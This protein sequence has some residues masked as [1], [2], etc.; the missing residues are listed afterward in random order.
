MPLKES[1]DRDTS[2]T[3]VAAFVPK[4]LNSLALPRRRANGG[5]WLARRWTAAGRYVEHRIATSDDLQDADGV[6]V[7]NFGQA[8][9]AA[10]EWWRTELRREEG[11]DTRIA[12]LTVAE[13]VK[14]YQKGL[15]RR[16]GKSVYHARRAS[17]THILPALGSVQVAKLTAKRIQ[18]WHA[19]L[20]P[21]YV[22]DT[23]RT[24]FPTL[25]IA[26]ESNV[27]PMRRTS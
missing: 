5:T 23:I 19:H 9:H 13:A 4:T 27:A 1:L 20:A 11:H 24:H 10:R 26:G 21:S 12:P 2:G 6:A 14:D 25:G 8:Q 22:A 16:G 7:L 17:E 15:E 18:D 3:P